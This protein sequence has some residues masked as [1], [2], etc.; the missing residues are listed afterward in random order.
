MVERFSLEVPR[1]RLKITIYCAGSFGRLD[2][3][4]RSDIDLFIV[5]DRPSRN[6]LLEYRLFSRL[7]EVNDKLRYPDFSNEGEYLRI[8]SLKD[9]LQA[10]G[11]RRD[12]HDN[13]FTARMLMLLEST[14]VY[15][16]D[17]YYKCLR[18]IV[19]HYF[20]DEKWHH[21]DFNPLFLLNDVLRYWRTLCLNYEEIRN[22]ETAEWRKKNINLKFSRMLTVFGTVLAIVTLPIC[23][24][25]QFLRLCRKTPLERF[26]FG[27]DNLRD[28]SMCAEFRAFLADYTKFLGW[29]D[30]RR[31]SIETHL[32]D[33]LFMEETRQRADSFSQFIYKA[34]MHKRIRP[35]YRRY[36]TI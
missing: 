9:M 6:R 10:T 23:Q 31:E 1:K 13:L 25:Q 5:S 26:A 15:A 29:K 17:T 3:G 27:L 18:G 2:A 19:E 7:I 32:K 21:R 35:E 33:S 12:D 30:L 20:R 8:Y 11:S 24:K 16:D 22:D 28:P 34:L 4:P 14:P 36:L